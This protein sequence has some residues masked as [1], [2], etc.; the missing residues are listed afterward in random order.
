MSWDNP[1]ASGIAYAAVVVF[2]FAT[3]YLNLLPYLFRLTWITLGITTA[4]EIVGKTLFNSG[5]A[6][7]IRPRKYYVVPKETL[8]ALVGDVHELINFFVIEAQRIV[9]AEN[10]YASA[11]VRITLLDTESC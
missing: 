8:D 2:I 10:I 5:F 11:A 4:A 1:R 6:S 7:Q 9:F 3:R